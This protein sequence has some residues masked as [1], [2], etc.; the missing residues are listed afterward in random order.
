MKKKRKIEYYKIELEI[1]KKIFMSKGETMFEALTN[2]GL[3]WNEIKGKGII[4]I[5]KGKLSYE[6]IFNMAVLRRI[7]VNKTAREYWAKSLNLLLQS[8]K[9]TNIPEK[10]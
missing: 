2:F 9:Q 8:S 6:H 4:R 10:L 5:K 7:M 1:L 3:D